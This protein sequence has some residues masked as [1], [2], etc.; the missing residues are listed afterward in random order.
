MPAAASVFSAWGMLMS[1]LRRDYIV[2]RLFDFTPEQSTM[3]DGLI[4]ET[5]A[6]AAAKFAEEGIAAG[7]MH[8]V[9]YARLRYQN[10]EHSVEVL[11][12]DAPV[13]AAVVKAVSDAFHENYQRHYTYRLD[14]PVEFVGLHIVASAEVG[15]LTVTD[16]PVTG[17]KLADTIKGHRA[18]DYALEGVHEATIY[19]G[20]RFEPGMA[21]IG[22]AII[23]Q[24]GSTTVIHPG[25]SVSID[26]YANIHIDISGATRG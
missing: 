4:R 22:P 25:Q 14:A 15:K 10:Q 16:H 19:D 9:T 17:L 21:F 20:D 5:K 3:V 1:D 24:K 7:Q 18:V 13:D 8:F 2:T 26:R 23:E 12:P 6:R 11:V